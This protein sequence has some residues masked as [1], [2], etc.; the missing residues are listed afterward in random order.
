IR[1]IELYLQGGVLKALSGRQ[2]V[3]A[4]RGVQASRLNT[5]DRQA[6]NLSSAGMA[7]DQFVQTAHF[8][9]E[10]WQGRG[11]I[12]CAGGVRYFTN[13]WICVQMLRKLECTLPIELWHIGPKELD[14]QM[15]SLIEPLGVVCRDALQTRKLFPARRLKGWALKSYAVL[16]CSFRELLFLDA[17]NVPV[18]NPEF[19]FQ[20]SQF[21]R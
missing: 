18:T 13:A 15:R 12:I 3:A 19:L 20:T 1:R 9:A 7:C 4:Q 16:H 6:L 21:S 10:P 2:R 17:D 5:F 11:I 8:P 14:K